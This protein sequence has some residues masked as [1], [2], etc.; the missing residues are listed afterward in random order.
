[1]GKNDLERH[2][3]SNIEWSVKD[4]TKDDFSPADKILIDVPCTGTGVIGRKPDIRWRRKPEDIKDMAK[5]QFQILNHMSQ[6]LNPGG[7]LVYG[8]CSLEP[9]ENWNV[10]EHFLKLKS[11]F[12]L[13]AGSSRLPNEWMNEQGC[14]QTLPHVHGVDGMFAAKLKRK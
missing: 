9:E 4:G 14:L 3:H 6:F 1:L 12:Q 7:T 11:G 2:G 13:V 8:T 10:V 5:L